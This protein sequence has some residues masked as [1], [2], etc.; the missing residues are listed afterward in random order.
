M[1][2]AII[3]F[4]I[5]LSSLKDVEDILN[6]FTNGSKDGAYQSQM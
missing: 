1:H 4:N 3:L 5:F 2:V 6:K